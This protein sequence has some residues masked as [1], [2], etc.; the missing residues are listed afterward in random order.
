MKRTLGTFFSYKTLSLPE[1]L[2]YLGTHYYVGNNIVIGCRYGVV[3]TTYAIVA[4]KVKSSSSYRETRDLFPY[5]WG[6][7][8]YLPSHGAMGVI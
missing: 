2:N 5:C 7:C 3:C 1:V 4:A 8:L 6:S